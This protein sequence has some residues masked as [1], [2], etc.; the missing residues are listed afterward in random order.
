MYPINTSLTR[1]Q[2]IKNDT[3]DAPDIIA[4]GGWREFRVHVVFR[5]LLLRASRSLLFFYLPLRT[6][7]FLFLQ[8]LMHI[9]LNPTLRVLFFDNVQERVEPFC[10]AIVPSKVYLVSE[11]RIVR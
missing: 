8:K 4:S 9:H 7:S 3:D 5:Y 2:N 11:A 10:R 6:Q 1:V